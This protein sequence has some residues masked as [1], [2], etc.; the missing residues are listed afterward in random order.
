M[1]TASPSR[2]HKLLSGPACENCGGATRIMSIA[3]HKRLKRRH[4]WTVECLHCE[5][6]LIVDM[7][8]PQ[9]TH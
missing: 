9:R 3:P 6:Q 2:E 5:R 7:P 1:S 8:A 4:I